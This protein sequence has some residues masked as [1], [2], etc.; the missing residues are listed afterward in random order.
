[1]HVFVIDRRGRE[2][3]LEADVGWRVM[4]VIRDW[5]LP[6]R[7]ECGGAGACAT[8]HVHVDPDWIGRL[9]PPD[10]EELAR[11]DEA[12]GVDGTS[13]LS[14]QILTSDELDGLRVALAPGSEPESAAA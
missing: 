2:H 8:C 6:I 14:C 13:R 7:A 5:G 4:E 10:D 1:M 3:R 11:L 12:P 9:A